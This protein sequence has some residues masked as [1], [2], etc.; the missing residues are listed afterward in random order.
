MTPA[1]AR[2]AF[3]RFLQGSDADLD[4]VEGALLIAAEEYPQLRPSLYQERIVRMAEE[5]QRRVRGL[6]DAAAVVNACNAFFFKENGFRGNQEDY[7]D[8]RN[9]YLN[10]VLD[11]HLGIPITLSVVYVATAERAGLPFKG[12]GMPGHFLVKYAPRVAEGEIFIDPFHQRTLTREECAKMLQEMYGDTT[13]MRPSFLNPTGTRQI[14]A[15]I[16]NNLKAIYLNAGDL[17]RA[18]AASDRIVMADP[19]LTSEWR[20]RGVI[21]F[22]LHRDIDALQDLT[23]YLAIRPEPEDAARV[24]QLRSQL[25]GRLN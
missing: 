17:T 5:L 15:R 4:L 12:V 21:E 9:S 20:D 19:H 23:R 24:R 1:E 14:L 11:R 22:Q 6:L 13:P 3:T 10:E 7:Y 18:L 8:P 16:L 2:A 25:L